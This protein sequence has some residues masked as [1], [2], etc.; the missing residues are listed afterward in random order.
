MICTQVNFRINRVVSESG[1]RMRKGIRPREQRI[2]SGF[3]FERGNSCSEK[4]AWQ[5]PSGDD[6]AISREVDDAAEGD[7]GEETGEVEEAAENREIFYDQLAKSPP[8]QTRPLP[9]VDET[10]QEE[11]QE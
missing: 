3:E 10:A 4:S 6:D 1:S 9:F 7:Q 11:E 2:S 5:G 8:E